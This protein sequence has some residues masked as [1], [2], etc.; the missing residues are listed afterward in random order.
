LVLVVFFQNSKQC[1]RQ[2]LLFTFYKN[3]N[4]QH[5]AQPE[6]RGHHEKI[7]IREKRHL[8]NRITPKKAIDLNA[9]RW[10]GFQ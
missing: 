4:R 6:T 2:D 9:E 3:T 8:R 5:P 7:E 1:N 10:Q